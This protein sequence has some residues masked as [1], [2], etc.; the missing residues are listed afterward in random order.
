M[1]VSHPGF[2]PSALELLTE[3]EPSRSLGLVP[4]SEEVPVPG[5]KSDWV[6]VLV[7]ASAPDPESIVLVLVRMSACHQA[8]GLM[9]LG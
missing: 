8:P 6:S 1:P 7:V 2:T 4:A 5:L 9:G 3:A